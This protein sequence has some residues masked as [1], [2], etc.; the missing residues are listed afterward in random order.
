[1]PNVTFALVEEAVRILHGVAHH[2]PVLTSCHLDAR[3]TGFFVVGEEEIVQAMEFA[4]ER[5]K[6][7][8]DPQARWRWFR[9]SGKSHNSSAI[10][11]AWCLPEAMW[12][13]RDRISCSDRA[14]NGLHV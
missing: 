8:I 14:V 9:C 7:V 11:S 5:L 4:Y 13:G 3:V 2:T 12:N 1:M 10:G 6:L